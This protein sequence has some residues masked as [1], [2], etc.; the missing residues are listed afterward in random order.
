MHGKYYA[1]SAA[2]ALFKWLEISKNW[3]FPDKSVSIRYQPLEGTMLIDSESVK[4]LE[5]VENVRFLFLIFPSF[6]C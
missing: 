1:L 6:A 3:I 4:N 5:L 2:S